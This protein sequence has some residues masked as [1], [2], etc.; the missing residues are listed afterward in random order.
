MPHIDFVY[1]GIKYPSV[2][3]ILSII[4]KPWLEKWKQK[5]SL[6]KLKTYI[7]AKKLKFGTDLP[8]KVLEKYKFSKE[9]FWQEAEDLSKKAA[10]RGKKYHAELEECNKTQKYITPLQRFY[11]RW[12]DNRQWL[13]CRYEESLFSPTMGFGGSFDVFF[14]NGKKGILGDFKFN[15]SFHETTFWQLGGYAL[16]L[17]GVTHLASLRFFEAEGNEWEIECMEKNVEYYKHCFSICLSFY[18][19]L[20][21]NKLI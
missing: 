4:P 1:K 21:E 15:R 9:E 18:K 13:P 17:P 5:H 12:I 8:S 10:D 16:L 14:Q 6:T 11:K 3:E 20:K 7:E 2:T 19:I